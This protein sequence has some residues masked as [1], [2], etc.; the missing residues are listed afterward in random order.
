MDYD[1]EK[2]P[3]FTFVEV[4]TV[5]FIVGITSA[6]VVSRLFFSNTELIA[7]TEVLKSHL[8]YA[9]ARA[10]NSE[11]VWGLSSDGSSYWLFRN[12][13]AGNRVLLPGE[14]ADIVALSENEITMD[15]FTFSFD[16]W[17]KPYT[18][19]AATRLQTSNRTLTL[20]D[21]SENRFV[22]ITKNTGF[23]E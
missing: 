11:E 1:F 20:T 9:Q 16:G 7:Q 5:I 15:S 8:R 2:S 13:D 4:I 23:I 22:I 10:M 21:S 18:D 12:R 17:G 19:E 3:G 14:K 6:I